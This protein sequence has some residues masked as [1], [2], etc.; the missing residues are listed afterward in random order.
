LLQFPQ[1]THHLWDRYKIPY[2]LDYDL[3]A[4]LKGMC[5][6]TICFILLDYKK[7]FDKMAKDQLMRLNVTW[8]DHILHSK[9][10]GEIIYTY[11]W[12]QGY[13]LS[14]PVSASRIKP[15]ESWQKYVQLTRIGYPL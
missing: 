5:Y 9:H 3:L 12:Q 8:I 2:K 14:L 1:F 4:P 15:S 13:P 7:S 6:S 11:D 10:H